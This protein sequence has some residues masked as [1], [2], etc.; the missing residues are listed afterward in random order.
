MSHSGWHRGSSARAS[1]PSWR[2]PPHRGEC[3]GFPWVWWPAGTGRPCDHAN[4]KAPVAAAGR[5]KI[6]L[7]PNALFD[8][9]AHEG[10]E[11]AKRLFELR[12]NLQVMYVSGYTDDELLHHGILERGIVLLS[13]PFDPDKLV[14]TVR[15]VL[16]AGESR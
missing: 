9:L 2:T 6:Y 10:H 15:R 11:L 14:Q 1:D 4:R 8:R 13:K 12:P 16:D 3:A 5:L 7:A